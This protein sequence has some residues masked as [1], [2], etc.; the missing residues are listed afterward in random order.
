MY[1]SE[2]SHHDK[3]RQKRNLVMHPYDEDILDASVDSS[4]SDQR[5][6]AKHGQFIYLH[7][8]I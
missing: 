4:I 6:A 2:K 3:I 5:D 8:D 1:Y 7:Y